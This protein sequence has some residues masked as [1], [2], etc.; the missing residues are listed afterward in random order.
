[1]LLENAKNELNEAPEI[2]KN[3]KGLKIIMA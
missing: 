3:N 2:T 1:M